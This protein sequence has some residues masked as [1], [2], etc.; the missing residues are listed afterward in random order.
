MVLK[1][2]KPIFS[3]VPDTISHLPFLTSDTISNLGWLVIGV[4]LFM[5][6]HERDRRGGTE[7]MPLMVG[8]GG[9]TIVTLPP[10]S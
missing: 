6:R 10:R 5:C 7:S 4:A 1:L 3:H 2:V 9:W 8:M